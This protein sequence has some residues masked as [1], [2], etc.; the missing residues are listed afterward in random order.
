MTHEPDRP[1]R[2]PDP[3]TDTFTPVPAT[4][5][6][7]PAG[8]SRAASREQAGK[9]ERGN[10]RKTVAGYDDRGAVDRLVRDLRIG[11]SV[12]C[13]SIMSAPWG[14]GIA[15]REAGSFHVV[16]EGGGW[17]EVDGADGPVAMAAGDVAVLPS[18]R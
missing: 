9:R 13:R 10:V 4:R 16:V 7:P 12:L 6:T 11:S 17:L 5:H 2:R 3:G 8:R 15:G 14:F 18:G 1:T